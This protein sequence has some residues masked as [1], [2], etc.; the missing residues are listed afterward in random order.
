MRVA[1][2]NVNGIRAR[3]SQVRDWIARDRPDAVCLQEIKAKPE[4]IP[5][6]LF[7]SE[8]YWCY[9]HGAGGYSGVALHVRKELCADRPCFGHPEFDHETRIV[10]A[11]VAGVTIAS[12]YVPNG[13]KDYAA[14]LRFLES[15]EGYARAAKEAGREILL[16]GDLNVARQESGERGEQDG[17]PPLPPV[18]AAVAALDLANLLGDRVVTLHAPDGV[19]VLPGQETIADRAVRRGDRVAHLVD[20]SVPFDGRAGM[21][22]DGERARGPGRPGFDTAAT[23]TRLPSGAIS[24]RSAPKGEGAG[25]KAIPRA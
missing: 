18:T 9:W 5:E 12:V 2:W 16:C 6:M 25:V 7:E 15:L 13:G 24:T 14:K 23:R 17:E 8:G 3:E 22:G 21:L 11:N 1:T 19:A 10:A 4:Q 20:A